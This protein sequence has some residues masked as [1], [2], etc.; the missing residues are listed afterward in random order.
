MLAAPR[1]VAESERHPGR[2][3]L[4]S[5]VISTLGASLLVYGI[6][7]SATAG[8][9]DT[10][11]LIALPPGWCCSRCSWPARRGPPQPIMPLRLFASRERVGAYAARFLFTG[12]L[13]SSTFFMTQYL[14]GV[15]GYSPLQA[16]L[17]FLPLTL[18]VLAVACRLPRL[19]RRF[20]NARLLDRR[21][22]L[23][24][25]RHGVAEPRGRRHAVRHRRR[26]ADDRLRHRAGLRAQHAHQRGH[27]RRRRRGRGR[28][29]RTRQ[30]RPPPRRR[31]R[32]RHPRHRVRRRR[33]RRGDPRELLADRVSAALT[34]AT[35]LVGARPRSS[36]S[37]IRPRQAAAPVAE[38]VAA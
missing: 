17:A 30:R 9:D 16:G 36:C 24:P 18:V 1:Y 31:R 25:D 19:T 20:G 27:G 3:D 13:V 23:H 38:T 22:R 12:A 6:V 26:A 8:W 32:P 5:G 33:L 14:Q 28:R 15:S 21:D 10:V 35:V 29:G 7:R 4:A 34:G 37:I 2:F 11:T